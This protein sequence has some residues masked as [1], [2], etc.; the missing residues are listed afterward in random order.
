MA[1]RHQRRQ[2][3]SLGT[4]HIDGRPGYLTPWKGMRCELLRDNRHIKCG[5]K[6]VLTGLR[7]L[8]KVPVL[9]DGEAEVI[10]VDQ[11]ML[12]LDW[13]SGGE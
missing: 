4:S 5:A 12:R 3:D 2:G 6:G 1:F 9:F 10:R 8:G 7:N 13:K 11:W